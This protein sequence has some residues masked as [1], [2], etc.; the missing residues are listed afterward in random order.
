[1]AV[2]V[3][4]ATGADAGYVIGPMGV[5]AQSVT[6]GHR[7]TEYYLS[8]A[9]KGG[10][11]PGIWIG[12]GLADLGIHDGD[13]ITAED[14]ELFDAIYGDF[15]DP[16]TGEHLGARPREV[17]PKALDREVQDIYQLKL[18]AEPGATAER[19]AQLLTEARA[20]APKTVVRYYDTTFSP[21]KTITL[22]HASALA[23]A[24]EARAADDVK[25]AELWESRAAG[26]WEEIIAAARVYIDHQQ[27]EAGYV[28]TGHH[29]DR[30]GDVEA[31]RFERA[32]DMPVAVFPQH[33]SRNGDPQLHVHILWLNR[34]QTESDG[35]WRAVDSRGLVR[36][37][38]D[39]AVKAAF[40]LESALERRYGFSWAYRNE[41]KGRILKDFPVKVIDKFSSRRSE[42]KHGV[43]QLVEAYRQAHGDQEPS[44][45]MLASM[46]QH[47]T[48]ATRDAKG[49]AKLDMDAKLREWDAAARKAELGTLR[50]LAR[51]IW[52]TMGGQ[53]Q[54]DARDAGPDGPGRDGPGQQLTA[55]EER[56]AMAAGLAQIQEE[57]SVWARPELV[58]A[59]AQHLPDHAVARDSADAVQ[60]LDD[61]ADRALRGEAGEEVRRLDAPE[62]PRVPDHLRRADGESV[63]TAHGSARYATAGQLSM[64]E[65][66]IM[67]AEERT[68]T[69]LDPE[70]AARLLGSDRATL[71]AQ[72]RDAQT[73]QDPDAR[74]TTGLRL[75]QAAA[76]FVV[77]TSN[78]RGE[79]IVAPA[80]SGKSHTAEQLKD[81]WQ[82]AGMGRVYGLAM[83]SNGR[84]V[85]TDF[86]FEN[87][88][89]TAEFLGHL[90]G[91]REARGVMDIGANALVIVD[92]STQVGMHDV[93]SV[94]RNASMKDAKVVMLGDP[95]QLPAV[96]SGG[97]FDMIASKLGHVQLTE[98]ARFSHEWE[99][100]A[101]LK[102]RNG[103][104]DALVK[105][106]EHGRLHAGSHEEMTE[107][108]VRDF[109]A[110]HLAGVS[111]IMPAY[112]HAD[113]DELNRRAQEYLRSW[114][115]L[116]ESASA[117]LTE[118]RVA[119]P[120]DLIRATDNNNH[121]R[122]DLPE[123]GV[124]NGDIMRVV[125]IDDRTAT[126]ER[127]TGTD[128]ETGARVWS[129]RF[130]LPLSYIERHGDLGYARTDH[131]VQGDTVTSGAPLISERDMLSAAYPAATRGREGNHLYVYSA[132]SFAD[133]Q[134]QG[135]PGEMPAPELA[136]HERLEAERAGRETGPSDGEHDAVNL[137]ANV[138]RHSGRELSATEYR[139]QALANADH[140]ALLGHILD[141]H[142]RE[143]SARRFTAALRGLL[144]PDQA[145][146]ALKDTDDLWRA[147]RHAELA[148][149]D[150]PA[151]LRAAVQ[152]RDLAGSRSVSAV[153]AQRVRS[154]TEHLPAQPR[155][156]WLSRV[157]H[158]EDPDTH[159]FLTEVAKGLDD[160]QARAGEHLAEHPPV[161]ASQA[162]GD[163]PEDPEERAQWEDKAGKI[164]AYRERYGWDHP[165]RAI[166][167]EPNTTN[168]EARAEWHNAYNAVDRHDGIDVRHL[169]D[170]Q[171]LVRREAYQ[172][173]TSWAPK[174]V[175]G[176]LRLAR[177]AE[178]DSK[179]QAAFHR[180]EAEAAQR[181]GDH[182]TARLQHSVADSALANVTRAS[183]MQREL[184]PVH[185]AR[186]AWEALTRDTLRAAEASDE[187]LHRR[188]FLA[189]DDK[190][191]SA[192]PDGIR[193]PEPD[194]DQAAKD[195]KEPPTRKERE[196]RQLAAL[197][198]GK[199]GQADEDVSRQLAE[200]REHARK[201]QEKIDELRSMRE[202]SEDPDEIDLGQPW[203]ALAD[204]D[205]E[206][207]LQ[208]PKPPIPPA[209]AVVDAAKERDHHDMEAGE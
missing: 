135:K 5:G 10:E 148:G 25:A 173:A 194:E 101:S 139:E 109:L 163:V 9:E 86:H 115:K 11:P 68:A 99:A 44:Q 185:E 151:V 176:E 62:W 33:T 56:A 122:T 209:E 65:R 96:E 64:E 12:A 157:P 89:N 54:S 118:G 45:R 128:R 71:E 169:T 51:D 106:D 199:D 66:I 198:L 105:Y 144:G 126:V 17:Q 207:I 208:P 1:M 52:D 70:T 190:L 84:N 125:S 113:R 172:R 98:V 82:A 50:D 60:I 4:F 94:L 88:Y 147:L 21:D 22:A 41:S 90:P 29:G 107:L 133:R 24:K 187:E 167:P 95:A 72:L 78:R 153:L 155:E 206:A 46:H 114:G 69:R 3:G 67:R 145:S 36:N 76:S 120:G 18:K 200:A 103:E 137:L 152:Q 156:S 93:D 162:L 2:T 160:R 81:A 136:R 79:A 130:E 75:D 49:D 28:R 141:E 27:Q 100:D 97:G 6:A 92:E 175:A 170:G 16:T 201:Q 168:P 53:R 143:D 61:L 30:V 121:L 181:K 47:V 73:A 150:G 38:Q 77:L 102:L 55:Q 85:L 119:H 80:G 117:A 40:A 197:G 57:K 131:G 177:M 180:H 186:T 13:L 140:P 129:G 39:G 26:V 74:T 91:E 205:R 123:R 196:Q 189:A 59:I 83:T 161:W 8:P 35:K 203:A 124:S 183:G 132:G 134:W 104:L 191:M 164:T 158:H 15:R 112:T 87:A 193:Y 7:A 174:Y 192:E 58:R 146:E 19:R 43:A 108:A 202:P 195:V 166:G 111:K 23:A 204:R 149:K 34:V 171:L 165:G 63:Y 127:Q 48:L 182:E 110:D 37:K 42:I 32:K 159:R 142:I 31:G 184:E 20:E 116:D 138:L 154:M 179:V 188:G 178:H 14:H